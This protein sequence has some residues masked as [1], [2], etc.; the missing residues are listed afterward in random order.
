MPRLQIV[1]LPQRPHLRRAASGNA[2]PSA[3][4]GRQRLRGGPGHRG[5]LSTSKFWPQ[6]AV[7]IIEDDAQNGPDHVDAHRTEAM[8]AEPVHQARG[9]WTRRCIPRCS[10]AAHDRAH[11]RPRADDAVRRRGRAD[12]REF[13]VQGRPALCRALEPG[14]DIDSRNTRKSPSAAQSAGFDLSSED[15]VD[16]Q[17]ST[18]CLGRGQGRRGAEPRRPCTR[19]SCASCPTTT[20]IEAA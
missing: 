16:E 11:P 4:C 7:F 14:I 13:S 5:A 10:H 17:T 20:T 18:A 8:V 12:V 2:R 9:R 19:R 6:T 15:L 3:A 1:R